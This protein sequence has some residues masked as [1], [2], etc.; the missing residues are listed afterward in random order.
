MKVR[1][2]YDDFKIADLL[3][4]ISKPTQSGAEIKVGHN[5]MS[6]CNV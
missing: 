3:C 4:G 6:V 2:V 5:D 1:K